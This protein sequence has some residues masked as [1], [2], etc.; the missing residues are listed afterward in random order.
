MRVIW[1]NFAIERLKEIYIYYRQV[2]GR[3]IA[4][5]INN[6][7]FKS[8]KQ[9]INHPKSGQLE[10][11]L[12]KLNEGYRYLVVGNYKLIYKEV[13]EGVLIT[14]VFDTRQNPVKMNKPNK[15]K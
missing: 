7:I 13:K 5:K 3:K 11:S 8:S 10:E 15:N 12:K 6:Q 14:D 1:S 4:L 9:L 2:A